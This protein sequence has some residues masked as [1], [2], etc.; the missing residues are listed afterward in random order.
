MKR[1]IVCEKIGETGKPCFWRVDVDGNKVTESW[2]RVGG[3][4]QSK[5]TVFKEGKNV[6]RSNETSPEEQAD[7][8]ACTKA[9]KK[10]D[11]GYKLVSGKLSTEV[12]KVIRTDYD[13][14]LPM[15]AKTYEDQAKKVTGKIYLQEKIDG[16]RCLINRFTGAM[17]SRTRKPITHLSFIGEEVVKAAAKLPKE[18]VWIDGELIGKKGMTFNETQTAIRREK[19][20][21]EALVKSMTYHI[22][23]V[24]SPLPWSERR[25]LV[26]A[27]APSP[28]IH[29][30]KDVLVDASELDKYH[31]KFVADGYEGAIIRL[32][33]TGYEHKRS[34]SLIK[35]KK[36][37]DEEYL[38][39]GFT[40]EKHNSSLLGAAILKMKDGQTFEARPAM[41][42]K[43]KAEIWANRKQYI[44]KKAT[45][46]F[47][48]KDAKSGIPRFPTLL[49]FRD[50]SDID[51]K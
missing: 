47:Q 2:G 36:F 51:S 18:I 9:R 40:S 5:E 8:E 34:G 43:E 39:T 32:D 10:L 27:I 35:H 13:V 44:G 3:A 38:V 19:N 37:K 4:E 22:F 49:R 11:K 45:I 29:I 50:E 26:A 16:N 6:G 25:E 1:T 12:A 15:L 20:V 17:Y 33:G 31:D 28:A 48:E 42:E 7:F 30:V 46:K 14:V 23:D 41:T 21:D 24:V